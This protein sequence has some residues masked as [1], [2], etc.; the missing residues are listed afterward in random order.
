MAYT[1]PHTWTSE[2][3]TVALMNEINNNIKALFPVGAYMYFCRSATTSETLL[4]DVWLECNGFSVLRATY[5]DLNTLLS[6]LGYPFGTA[7]GTHMTLPDFQGRAPTSM[8]SGGN[9]DVN[10]LGDSDGVAKASRTPKGTVS[11]SGSATLTGGLSA[12]EN[13]AATTVQ[14]GVGAQVASSPHQHGNSSYSGT[15]SGSGTVPGNYLVGG[16]LFIKAR[17]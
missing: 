3:A 12:G 1:T 7:D 10:A 15:I 17:T 8:S 6:G 11:V 4:D 5:P 16:V 13:V 14:S 2:Q 9:G